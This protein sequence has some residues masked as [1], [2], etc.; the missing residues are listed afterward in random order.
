MGIRVGE[1]TLRDDAFFMRWGGTGHAP[2]RFDDLSKHPRILEPG[3]NGPSSA[4]GAFQIT[5]STYDDFAPKLGITDFSR[6][7]QEIIAIAIIDFEG[8]LE[9]VLA[10]NLVAA[11]ALLG[12]RWASLPSSAYGQST[13]KMQTFN[14]VFVQQGGTIGQARET[15]AT[16]EERDLSGVPPREEERSETM[17]EETTSG[18]DWAK[19]TQV[20]GGI[21]SF[22]NP[23]AGAV[24]TALS[25][26]LQDK[27]AKELGRHTN[28]PVMAQKVASDLSTA[29]LT[30]VKAATGKTDDLQA[31][32][33]LQKSPEAI[34]KVEAAVVD[35][36]A[37][38]APYIDAIAKN[39]KAAWDA[40]VAGRNAAGERNAQEKWDSTPT[41]VGSSVAMVAFILVGLIVTLGVQV[42]LAPDHKPDPTITGI[43]GTVFGFVLKA[44][45]EI[46]AYRFD[47]TKNSDAN[48]ALDRAIKKE[49]A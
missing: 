29:M 42:W 10:G 25:P 28:D 15:T 3:P 4:A 26:L 24:L 9:H 46:F 19:V 27:V 17:T 13:I 16:I 14:R 12:G 37:R 7:S 49:S 6:E 38:I 22:F 39:Q 44:Y 34:A 5:M 43:L 18:I 2:K 45:L 41:L 32:L 1:S 35:E 40:E 11:V 47:G 36:L 31:V 23:I 30:T 33:A 8:A 48:A 21:A 20:A